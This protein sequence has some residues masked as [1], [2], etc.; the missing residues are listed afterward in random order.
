M[1][2]AVPLTQTLV[3]VFGGGS[4]PWPVVVERFADVAVVALCVVLAVTHHLAVLVL[5]TLAGVTVTL[6][7][8]EQQRRNIESFLSNFLR[9]SAVCMESPAH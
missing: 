3:G 9:G 4:P 7:P 1:R 5:H 6:T 2:T 8:E